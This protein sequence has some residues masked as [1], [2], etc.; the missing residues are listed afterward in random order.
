MVFYAHCDP[1][2][3]HYSEER[4]EKTTDRREGGHTCRVT[5]RTQNITK[6]ME[7]EGQET[8]K[9]SIYECLCTQLGDGDE[10]CFTSLHRKREGKTQTHTVSGQ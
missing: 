1:C 7:R 5:E 2:T 10:V 3:C 4:A 6:K 9:R 8:A